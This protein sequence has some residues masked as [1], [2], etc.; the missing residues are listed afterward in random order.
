MT[1]KL[2][3]KIVL[4]R[5]QQ[6]L[7]SLTPDIDDW[8]VDEDGR[9]CST[10]CVWFLMLEFGDWGVCVNPRSPR[11][12]RLTWE[13]Q[14]CPAWEYSDWW[15]RPSEEGLARRLGQKRSTTCSA[16]SRP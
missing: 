13:H 14:G 9:D 15:D 2:D 8:N 12:G 4:N 5:I 3:R 1:R 10:D 16:D 11:V 6:H 7:V